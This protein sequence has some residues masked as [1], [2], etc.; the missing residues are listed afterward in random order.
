MIVEDEQD[1]LSGNVDVD[2]YHVN[3]DISN[4]EVS[5]GVSPDFARYLQT[6]S[7]MHTRGIHQQLQTDIVEHI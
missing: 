1:T 3:D 5:R 2:Y 6:K 7:V 4:V